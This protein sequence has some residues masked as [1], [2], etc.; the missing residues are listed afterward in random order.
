MSDDPVFVSAMISVKSMKGLLGSLISTQKI[1]NI[2]TLLHPQ[3]AQKLFPV[4]EEL[5]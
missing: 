2:K 1:R 4:K 3:K 5:F